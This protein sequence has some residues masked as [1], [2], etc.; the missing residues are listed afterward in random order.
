MASLFFKYR[1]LLVALPRQEG[2]TELGVRLLHDITKRPFTSQSLFLAK[3][4]KS[5][6]RATREKFMRLFPKDQF[7]VNTENV[8]LK[9][10]PTSGIYMES[11]DKDPDRIR[12]GTYAMIHWSEVAFSKI[13]LGETIVSVFD[14]VCA[15]TLRKTRGYFYGES[16]NN[17]KNGWYD[18]WNNAADY[19]MKTIKLSLSDLVYMGLV[20]FEEYEA[21]RKS[22]HPDVFRQEYECEWVTFQGR[23]YDEFS[24]DRHV[25]P[26]M[27]PPE[28]WQTVLSALDWGYWPSATCGLFAYTKG[29]VL[30]IFDEHY[31]HKELAELTADEI[32]RKRHYWNMRQLT[33][34]ADHEADRI[35]ELTRRKI[36]C[37]MADKVNVMGARI[38][39][40]ELLYFDRIKIHPR[41]KNLIRELT[42]ATWHEKKEGELDPSQD[43]IGHYDAEAALR[44]L[45]RM[46][47]DFTET[48][49]DEGQSPAG[50]DQFTALAHELQRRRFGA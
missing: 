23:A 7:T 37:G 32:E 33:M 47:S 11:V 35:E 15:P 44:Y 41:C 26:D 25:D 20:P 38:Q 10:H 31:K 49:P 42:S 39:I 12:G 22:T 43:S 46:L 3:D 24:E 17:G 1:R 5:G 4:K 34:V 28:D 14:K 45:T 21:I 8:F 30:N 50:M 6:K 13:E 16:T 9:K 2:K 29:G 18:L 19:G 40:K 48:E 36:P 27:S